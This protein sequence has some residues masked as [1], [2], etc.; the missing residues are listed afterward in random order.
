MHYFWVIGS[1]PPSGT[2]YEITHGEQ[3]AVIV[4]VGGGIRV[5]EVGER[6][7]LDPYSADSICDGAHG[8]PLIPWPNR[9]ADG[10]YRFEGE[11]FQV[12]L[13]EPASGNAI[14]GFLR[15]QPWRA[16]LHE[17]GQVEMSARIHPRPGYPFDLEATVAYSLGDDGLRVTTTLENHGDRACPVGHGQHPY[18]SAGGGPIDECRLQH[19]GR[20]RVL[21]N[22]RQLPSGH[23]E[24]AGTDFDF[25]EAR[26]LG[27]LEIDFAFTD[28]IRDSEGRAWTRLTR[29]DGVTA[30]LW[31]DRSYPFV[32]LYTGDTLAPA[33]RRQ[34]LGTE[35]MTCAPDGFNS[36]DGLIRLEPGERTSATWG[37][38]LEP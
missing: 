1:T 5:Y 29:A 38:R 20:V 23:E 27:S 16:E 3:R 6:T 21:T 25:L 24:V 31:V 26:S 19:P 37:A 12:P 34:G 10:R 4:E 13:T 11:D 2:Q 18:L 17:T 7:V 36:G 14:H 9:L 22:E 32:E 35:P 8:T 30:S 33:R 28:L 15:W